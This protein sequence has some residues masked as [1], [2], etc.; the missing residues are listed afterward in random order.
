MS[1]KFLALLLG[2]LVG[3]GAFILGM[4]TGK[5]NISAS[6]FYWSLTSLILGY[7]TNNAVVSITGGN[8]NEK[9]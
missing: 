5:G 9:G 7:I 6:T 2:V 4:F 1:R 8:K 3:T